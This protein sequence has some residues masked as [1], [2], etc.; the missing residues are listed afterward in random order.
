ML[1]QMAILIF[2]IDDLENLKPAMHYEEYIHTKVSPTVTATIMELSDP[3]AVAAFDK[4]VDKP[5]P[6]APAYNAESL[7]RQAPAFRPERLTSLML[8]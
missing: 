6:Q 7:K 3:D 1:T 2:T 8:T 4:I 5:R